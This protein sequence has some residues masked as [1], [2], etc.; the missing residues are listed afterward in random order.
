M[1]VFLFLL[2]ATA[3]P[4]ADLRLGIVGTDTSHS[5]AF[6]ALLNDPANKNHLPGARI[7]AA[8]KGGSSDIKESSGRVD[9]YADELSSKY[10][11]E[12]TPDIPTLLTKVDA[13]LLESVDGR[14]HLEQFR[15]IVKAG[16]PVF[17]DKPLAS[18]LF[19]A[20]EIARLAQENNVKWFSA[21]VLRFSD[22]L[23]TLKVDGLNGVYAWGPGPLEEHHQLSLS[24]YGVHT[25]ETLYTMLGRGC[26]E[27]TFTSSDDADVV[28]GK[29]RDG[30]IGTIRVIR[31]YSAF[32]VTAFSAKAIKTNEKDL[33]TGYQNLVKEIIQF[34]QSGKPP[35]DE[36][37]TL[38]MFAFM[39]AAQ[40]SKDS[41]GTPTKLR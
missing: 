20:R 32:G 30:R 14:K 35:I 37:E 5:V 16:K 10:G 21:S 27:V 18:T 28:T 4:A 31:P 12:L 3:L 7:V 24:W 36:N 26:E 17:I 41:G 8:Y 39:D 13:V 11:V 1:R 25:V 33:Y 29:W 2:A 19:D 23:P 9:K 15:E 38:E 6:T 34:F 40:R 22:V